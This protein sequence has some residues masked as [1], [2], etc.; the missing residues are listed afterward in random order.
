MS[1]QAARMLLLRGSALPQH[2]PVVAGEG[3]LAFRG[4]AA[5][6]TAALAGAEAPPAL[7][8]RPATAVDNSTLDNSTIPALN[9]RERERRRQDFL[10]PLAVIELP[11]GVESLR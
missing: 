11:P 3:D 8:P 4:R 9:S 5:G 6:R 2:C 7:V 1:C 10:L